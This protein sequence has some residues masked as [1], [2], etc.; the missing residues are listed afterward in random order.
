MMTF[1]KRLDFFYWKYIQK[2]GIN[3]H[4]TNESVRIIF[5]QFF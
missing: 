2:T 1:Q 3:Q 5:G 4:V